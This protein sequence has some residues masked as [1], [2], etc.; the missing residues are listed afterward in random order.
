MRGSATC[1]KKTSYCVIIITFVCLPLIDIFLYYN[2]SMCFFAHYYSTRSVLF[3]FF[4]IVIYLCACMLFWYLIYYSVPLLLLLLLPFLSFFFILPNAK[5]VALRRMVWVDIIRK[6]VVSPS[7]LAGQA[8]A[9]Y[10]TIFFLFAL[11]SF[12]TLYYE[13]RLI[14]TN[15][16]IN[17]SDVRNESD[18]AKSR[19]LFCIFHLFRSLPVFSN[20]FLRS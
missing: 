19:I 2:K 15:N 14:L 20:H 17:D 8:R 3:C 16:R 18:K 9:E 5:L 10:A 4:L 7:S 13:R 12:R 11:S 1:L 6:C